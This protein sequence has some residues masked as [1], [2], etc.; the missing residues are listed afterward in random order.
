MLISSVCVFVCVHEVNLS[1][2]SIH[3]SGSGVGHTWMMKFRWGKKCHFC[4]LWALWWSSIWVSTIKWCCNCTAR[5]KVGKRKMKWKNETKKE[6][7]E[8]RK[9]RSEK[10]IVTLNSLLVLSL[11]SGSGSQLSISSC[12]I[13]VLTGCPWRCPVT[14]WHHRDYRGPSGE[15]QERKR[16][17]VLQL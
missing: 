5:K 12:A 14:S 17:R 6:M 4:V 8:G 11:Y 1:I 10:D 3:S 16:D 13:C 2:N 7:K 9:N 15:W